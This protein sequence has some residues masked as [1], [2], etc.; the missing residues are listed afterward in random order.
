MVLGRWHSM[1]INPS[2]LGVS[3]VTLWVLELGGA[4]FLRG[5]GTGRCAQCQDTVLFPRLTSAG[6]LVDP[7]TTLG[8]A[9]LPFSLSSRLGCFSPMRP[10]RHTA[11][12]PVAAGE[13]Q[14]ALADLI[15][16]CRN[17]NMPNRAHR[18]LVNNWVIKE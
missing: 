10:R 14:V 9:S 4:R 17:C 12:L 6:L 2:S 1:A 7:V 5:P 11:G 8:T 3:S 16:G 13:R 15:Y 18:P